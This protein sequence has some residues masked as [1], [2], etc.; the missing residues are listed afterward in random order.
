MTQRP[1][2][3][4]DECGQPYVAWW[5]EH[6]IWN[7]IMGGPD[8]TDDPGGLLCPNCFLLRAGPVRG[9]WRLLPPTCAYP[10]CIARAGHPGGH[11]LSE[12]LA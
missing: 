3:P 7:G 6:V 8:A 9:A 2:G 11:V 5:T 12:F 4:C 10:R 1:D